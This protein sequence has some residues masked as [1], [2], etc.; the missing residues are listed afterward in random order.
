MS[1]LTVCSPAKV[2]LYL[3]VL[4]LRPDGY[5]ELQT[6]FKTID[7]KDKISLAESGSGITV[8]SD[9]NSI[10]LDETNLAWRAAKLL[11]D[12][13][14]IKTGIK[15]F[16]EKNIPVAAGLGGGSSNAAA[17]LL[18]LNKL[19]ALGLSKN[20][21]AGFGRQLG[22]DVPFFVWEYPL[23]LATGIGEKITPLQGCNNLKF[24][25]VNP[26]IKVSTP[27][28]YEQW[29]K[30]A[31]EQRGLTKPDTDVKIIVRELETNRLDDLDSLLYNSLE[32][33]AV[34]IHPV[35]SNVKQ[36]LT[37]SGVAPNLVSGSG[38]TV[39]GILREG[40]EGNCL[41]KNI[42]LSDEWRVYLA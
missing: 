5:H 16:I 11:I 10:P 28:V 35:I 15:I 19:W 36:Y 26:G 41:K 25:L 22:A 18:G 14:R 42:A 30:L 32:P 4:G 27:T 8:G 24:I 2:N 23:A 9:N 21:L 37:D 40:K 33:A 6:I 20:I 29:D 13:C 1:N 31:L 12:H 39:F 38:P 7:L 34:S 3:N 17:V